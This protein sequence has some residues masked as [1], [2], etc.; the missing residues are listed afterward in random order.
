MKR[1]H[2][3][4][5]ALLTAL[6]LTGA[7][8]AC[9]DEADTPAVGSDTTAAN[10]A[11]TTA[12][13]TAET[14]YLHSAH[15]EAADF[16]GAEFHI[17]TSNNVN[18]MVYSILQNYAE[19]ENGD[20]INDALYRRDRFIE[21][22]YNV[23][24]VYTCDDTSS[25]S[26][27]ANSLAK[28]V[29]A[30]D[31]TYQLII[32]DHATVT[33]NLASQGAIYPLN[34][35]NTI[36]LDAEY[37]MPELNESNII[38]NSVY[39]PSCMISPRYFGSVYIMMFNREMAAELDLENMY[40]LV[41]D[42]KWTFDK[43]MEL[44]RLAVKDMDG[45]GKITGDGVDRL[46]VAFESH[47]G[48]VL[49]TGF[50]FVE[51]KN[52]TLVSGLENT[53]LIEFIQHF[54]DCFTE[55]GMYN[56]GNSNIDSDAVMNNG[57]ALF[58]NPCTFSLEEYRDLGYDYGLLPMPKL[59]ESQEEYI[60]FSQPW[61]NTAPSI[62]VTITGEEL[63][64]VGTLTDAM[65]AYGYDYIKPAVYD[66]VVRLK[67]T[68]DEQSAL[69]IDKIFSNVAIELS[70]T[71]WLSSYSPINQVFTTNLGKAEITTVYAKQ[72]NAIEAE[73]AGIMSAYAEFE[74]EL[75]G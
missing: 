3:F 39:Y 37:W 14:E 27:M 36:H 60:G 73:I 57:V 66:N 38:G 12:T 19:E 17:Y 63:E 62:P 8:A 5:A 21:E 54:V 25:A 53:A 15:L 20:V 13:E 55:E 52:D 59:D 44:G 1:T 18:G 48:F 30:G 72:K 56:I 4:P 16:G 64:M 67:G 2:I 7:L 41:N 68:R 10:D 51:N 74:A 42:G 33:K 6:F 32:Q 35:I 11:V 75:N 9:G 24:V 22:T 43:M 40:D 58:T 70:C 45:D 71:L 50:H 49:S 61:I 29:I 26:Q 46:G 23:D 34:Y 69:I 65:V 31:S 28:N 47:E